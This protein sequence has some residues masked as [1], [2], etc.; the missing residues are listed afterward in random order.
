MGLQ[1]ESYPHSCLQT[2]ALETVRDMVTPEAWDLDNLPRISKDWR[3][4]GPLIQE[5]T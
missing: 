5:Q 1:A 4:G 3:G 2:T